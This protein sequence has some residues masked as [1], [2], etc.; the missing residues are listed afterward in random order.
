MTEADR[1]AD[2][3]AHLAVAFS[4]PCA[5]PEHHAVSG[6]CHQDAEVATDAGGMCRPCAYCYWGRDWLGGQPL[7]E[8]SMPANRRWR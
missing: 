8:A 3:D 5:R 4:K 6:A 1:A 2:L 7:L